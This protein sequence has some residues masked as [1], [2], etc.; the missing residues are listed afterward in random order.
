VSVICTPLWPPPTG[1]PSALKE[2]LLRAIGAVADGAA[3]RTSK[4]LI[5]VDI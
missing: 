4:P 1:D 2:S 3:G 5:L